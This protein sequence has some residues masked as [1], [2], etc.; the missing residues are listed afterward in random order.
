MDIIFLICRNIIIPRNLYYIVYFN[1]II[2]IVNYVNI[3]II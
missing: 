2:K 1:L 3:N